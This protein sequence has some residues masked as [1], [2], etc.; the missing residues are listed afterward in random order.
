MTSAIPDFVSE[1]YRSA[2]EV[3]KLSK[4]ERQH[5]VERA[6]AVIAEQ[7]IKLAATGNIVSI[8]SGVVAGIEAI[9]PQ[10]DDMPDPLVSH[11]L[12]ECADDIRKLHI[13]TAKTG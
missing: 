6:A 11:I 4:F 8:S 10:V 7:R 13:L 3:S 5:L 9:L 2:N 12:L 1:L